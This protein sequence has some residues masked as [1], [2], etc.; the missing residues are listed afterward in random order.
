VNVFTPS[1]AQAGGELKPIMFWIY[2]GSL[3]FGSNSQAAYD[4]SSFA[5]NQ[6]VVLVAANYR[7]NGM[8]ISR[9]HVPPPQST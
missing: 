8:E 1:S 5:A 9:S 6:D 3:Q 7:T 2:G 4:G